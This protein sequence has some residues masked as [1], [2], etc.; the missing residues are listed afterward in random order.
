MSFIAVTVAVLFLVAFAAE[1]GSMEALL[2]AI[3]SIPSAIEIAD[4]YIDRQSRG[5]ERD[6]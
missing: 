6:S 3:L 1:R 5:G 4:R 2:V